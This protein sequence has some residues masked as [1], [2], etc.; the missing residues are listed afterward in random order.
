MEHEV[1]Y[2]VDGQQVREDF[3]VEEIM[4]SEYSTGQKKVLNP[5]KW[6]GYPEQLEWTAEPLEDLP[7]ALVREFHKR[8]PEAPM[9]DKLQKKVRRR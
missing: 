7:Q 9:D 4:G 8:Q 3:E 1:R 6:I 2:D 5:I